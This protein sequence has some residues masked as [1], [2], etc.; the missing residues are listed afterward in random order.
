MPE[1]RELNPVTTRRMPRVLAVKAVLFDLDGTLADTAPDLAAAL[2]RVRG[3]RGLPPLPLAQ[4]RP[5][6]SHG[7]RGL[8]GAGLG[9]TPDDVDYPV[10]RDAFLAQYAAA[11]CVETRLFDD[12][13]RLLDV[14]EERGLQ[15][16]IVTNKATRYTTPLLDALGLAGRAGTVICGDTTPHTKPHPAPLLAA[17]VEL[18]VDPLDCVYVGDAERDITAG[19]AARMLTLVARYGYIE[20]QELPDAWPAD[21]ILDA[22]AALLDWLPIGSGR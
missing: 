10:L 22:P 13:S 6:A 7:A 18:A 4:L 15:W 5:Y 3:E 11:L 1:A 21:G 16:G 2:N 12:V 9:M 17:A 20:P 19:V 14:I 8:L